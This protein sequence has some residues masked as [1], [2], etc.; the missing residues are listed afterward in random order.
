M[1]RRVAFLGD[2]IAARLYPGENPVGQTLMLDGMPF[3]VVGV[4]ESKMQTSM[5]N[6]P[7]A[8]RV[9]IPASVFQTMYGHRFVSHLLVR[10]RDVREAPAVKARMYEALGRRHNFDSGDERAVRVWDFV[11]EEKLTRRIAV[12]IQ[13]FLG[14]VGGLTLL[15]AGIGV[16]NIMYVVVRE[17]TREIGLKLA[18]GARKRHIMAADISMRRF[19]RTGYGG[20]VVI[21]R[22]GL[23]TVAQ[24]TARVDLTFPYVPGLLSF[25]ELPVLEAAW[26][27]SNGGP[28]S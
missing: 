11:E 2:S 14:V 27:S 18:V 15:V 23:T 16:A 19:G 3:T 20:I 5:N 26:A 22:D 12:G 7:D 28:T 8:D 21:E 24:A 13:I 10:P 9:I 1:K 25:R 17:R 4:M 6:G